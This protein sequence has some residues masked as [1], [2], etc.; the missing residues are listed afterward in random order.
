MVGDLLVYRFI[1]F[2]NY[3]VSYIRKHTTEDDLC[4]KVPDRL[5]EEAGKVIQIWFSKLKQREQYFNQKELKSEPQY[6]KTN[7]F[8]NV[9]VNE[10]NKVF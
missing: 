10:L 6:K 1:Q 2:I 3:E 5:K 4:I 9:A 7:T 8:I